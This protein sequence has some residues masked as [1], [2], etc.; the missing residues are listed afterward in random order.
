MLGQEFM[1]LIELAWDNQAA[2]VSFAY[3]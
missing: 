1:L 2:G 3:K